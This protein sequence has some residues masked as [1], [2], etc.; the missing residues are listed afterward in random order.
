MFAFKIGAVGA[1]F[2]LYIPSISHGDALKKACMEVT[3]IKSSRV[4]H[5]LQKTADQT[6]ARSEQLRVVTFLKYPDISQAVKASERR[7]DKMF[8]SK[9]SRF[10]RLAERRCS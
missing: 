9:F 2:L 3:Q 5:C 6:L 1:I 10:G 4:C 8:W 7:T